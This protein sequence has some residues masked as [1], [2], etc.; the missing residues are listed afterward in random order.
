MRSLPVVQPLADAHQ[1]KI[2]YLRLSLID[3]CN[4]RCTYCMPQEEFQ[5]VRRQELLSFEE[6]VRLIRVFA[7]MG[8]TRVRLTG[9]EPT[10]RRDLVD[11]VSRL[12]QIEGLSSIVMT[13]N[14]HLLPSLAE[15]LT[16]AGLSGVNVS[17][18]TLHP[19]KFRE[20]TVRGD[21]AVVIAGIDAAL[22]AGLEVKLN[23]VL[24][25]GV[26]EGE[27]GK[28]C[29]FAWQRGVV[30]RF[31]EHMP[32]SAGALYRPGRQLSAEEA[33]A[34]IAAHVGK[35]VSPLQVAND[36]T[37]P[38]RYF[39]VGGN[40]FGVIS[41][42]TEHFCDTCNRVRLSAEGALHPCLADDGAISLRDLVRAGAEDDELSS[43]IRYALMGKAAG[44]EFQ[45]SGEG[46]P[47]K[48][49]LTIGG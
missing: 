30:P 8:V 7:E 38:A 33:R 36:A 22:A 29:D 15:P 18:D 37:G 35:P 14:A 32:M 45:L 46:G 17:L 41:A 27:L 4:Y 11:L 28:L 47:R 40:E 21:L 2:K 43:A 25:R 24:L 13:T 48:H 31:I 34:T 19:E 23:T 6:I 26:N 5:Q 12:H 39:A 44:H 20:L 42:M 9:G 3:R 10:L 49:M 1:R 16:A